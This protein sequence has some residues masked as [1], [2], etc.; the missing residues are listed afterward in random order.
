MEKYKQIIDKCLDGKF[1]KGI[2]Q[3]DVLTM[4]EIFRDL[5]KLRRAEFIQS[6]IAAVLEKCRIVVE[7]CGIGY[8]AKI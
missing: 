1:P 2:T 4:I 7:P 3:S 8:V 6:S 5:V